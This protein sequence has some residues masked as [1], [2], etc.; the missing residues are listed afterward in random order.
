M[1]YGKMDQI[2]DLCAKVCQYGNRQQ[3]MRE[4]R[5]SDKLW[6]AQPNSDS[7]NVNELEHDG[8]NTLQQMRVIT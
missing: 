2:T 4:T 8:E 5:D 3:E 6:L 1:A 7:S